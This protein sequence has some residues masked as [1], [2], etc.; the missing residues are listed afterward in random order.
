MSLDEPAVITCALS[1]LLADREQCPAIPYSPADYAAEARRIVDEGGVHIHI[2]A[3][4]PS[5]APS[6][7]VEDFVAIKE[8]IVSEIGD[9][10]IMNFT[11]GTVG[12]PVAK[13][14]AYLEAGLPEVAA[15]NMGSMNY[16]KYSSKR[17]DFVFK[18]IF[19]NPFEEILEL[20]EAM[21]RL[22]IKPE[23]ECFDLGHVGSLAP[24]IDMGMLEAPLHADFIMGV[25]GGVPATTLN[26]AAMARN[27]P[28]GNHHWGVIGIGRQQ[29]TMVAAGLT[30]GGSVR[31]GLED[32]FYLPDR[33]M[34]RSNGDLIAKARQMCEDAGRRPATV[35]EA[36]LLLG[37]GVG[38]D[39]R[40]RSPQP[41]DLDRIARKDA[42]DQRSMN[43]WSG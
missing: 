10:A 2:H 28:A 15:L 41:G 24:L 37:I 35:T 39:G 30:L 4:T 31:V 3:R 40:A 11:T 27:M 1:G 18:M 32:N 21:R 42:D 26:L 14:V 12:V 33:T 5:G 8:A 38:H 36:R 34:A 13:R 23:H 43:S 20:L 16:A 9:A 19:A 17:K 6:Y 25:L 7:E 29:W 22:G